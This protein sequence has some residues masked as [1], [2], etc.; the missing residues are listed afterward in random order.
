M[1]KNDK[2]YIRINAKTGIFIL[3][4]Q[5][6]SDLDS[7]FSSWPL[8]KNLNKFVIIKKII[9]KVKMAIPQAIHTNASQ[10]FGATLGNSSS[11]GVKITIDEV[12]N[13]NK[14]K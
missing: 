1:N 13:K 3:W 7:L 12:N 9:A 5:L 8:D 4:N 6:I 11:A 10:P 14:P 2:R